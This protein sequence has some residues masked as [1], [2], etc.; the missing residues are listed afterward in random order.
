MFKLLL[1]MGAKLLML[2][3]V[4]RSDAC[5]GDPIQRASGAILPYEQDTK[6][7]CYSIFGKVPLYRTYF[8][9]KGVGGETPLDAALGLGEDGYSDLL[10][11]VSD[12][13]GVYN[14]YHK[15]GDI[16]ARL[17][18]L[19]LLTGAIESNIADDAVDV[20]SYY[21]HKPPPK[22]AEEAHHR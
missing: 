3:F 16:L 9:K 6:R 22:P 7:I 10:R 5:S 14:V 8:Y 4:M 2:F 20:E 19:K 18:G 12:Y 1:A 15:S 17:L 13:L 11:D 21:A